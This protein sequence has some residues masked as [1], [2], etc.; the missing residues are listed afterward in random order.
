MITSLQQ[1][2]DSNKPATTDELNLAENKAAAVELQTR[3]CDLGIL[4][5]M[6]GGDINTPFGP[7]AKADGV[8][9]PMTRNAI[10][11]FCRLA[12][13]EYV[14]RILSLDLLK[15]LVAA[16]PETFLP[17][18]F[19]PH[20]FDKSQ[21]RLARRILRCLHAKGYWIARSPNAYNI[22]Y[23]E[24]MNADGKENPDTFDR[25]N[26]RR[27]VIRIRPGG[28]PEIVIN[29]QATT[30]PGKFYTFHP[31]DP[32]G[33]ARIAF[34]QYKAWADGLHQGV[35]PALVQ[36]GDVRIHRDLDQNG[37]RSKKDPIVVGDW[38]GIN[39]H[40]TTPNFTPE[41]VGKYSAGCLVGQVYS[42]HLKF[43][44]TVRKDFRYQLNKS[45]LF[46][47]AVLAGDDPLLK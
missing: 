32:Q 37:K 4:D 6:F 39:Q 9:G 1:L 46:V 43:L 11:E 25:W 8:V 38:F 22:V 12:K 40:S 36:R 31:L 26:D 35:Q 15:A 21:T 34:G 18:W 45:Y 17:V 24:G 42:E 7:L 27:I 5:P 14:D 20:P 44:N 3:L 30:E 19:A 2:I 16:Q 28:K 41:L 13:I 29:H 10:F 23:V 33:A 47:S